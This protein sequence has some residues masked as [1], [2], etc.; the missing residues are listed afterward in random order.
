MDIHD[1]K[2]KP[3][4]YYIMIQIYFHTEKIMFHYN[5][6]SSSQ[7]SMLDSLN[8]YGTMKFSKHCMHFANYRRLECLFIHQ[9]I[10]AP[11]LIYSKYLFRS[12]NFHFRR[13]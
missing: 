3:I 7:N 5:V 12:A 8:H 2:Y 10:S 13:L 11:L 6:S 1:H 9:S 4:G